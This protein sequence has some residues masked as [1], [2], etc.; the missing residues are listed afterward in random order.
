MG[1]A[2]PAIAQTKAE[3]FWYTIAQS[4]QWP[5]PIFAFYLARYIND[6]SAS[7]TQ[8]NGGSLALGFADDGLYTG[9]INYIPLAGQNYWLIPLEGVQV[10]S[11]KVSTP[12]TH[13]AIDTSV[14]PIPY[15]D[16][17]EG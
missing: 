13:V 6:T 15:S 16:T 10:G 9:T 14:P 17:L 11:T 4:S 1:L 3:P 2:W 7:S 8:T 5:N 12:Q